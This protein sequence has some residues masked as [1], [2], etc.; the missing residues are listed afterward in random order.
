MLLIK[1]QTENSVYNY[2][3]Q[4]FDFQSSKCCHTVTVPSPKMMQQTIS[5]QKE[6]EYMSLNK[7]W[8]DYHQMYT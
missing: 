1:K 6:Q 8:N 3:D 4:I 5:Q 2:M 7:K